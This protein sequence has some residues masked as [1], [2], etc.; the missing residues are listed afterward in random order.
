MNFNTHA[1][2]WNMLELAWSW[3]YPFALGQMALKA[4]ILLLYFLKK[5]WLRK[6]KII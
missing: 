6:K 1:S 2:P 5:G 3:G 4:L